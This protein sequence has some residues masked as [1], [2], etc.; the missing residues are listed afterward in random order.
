MALM[1]LQ[2]FKPTNLNTASGFSQVIHLGL[3]MLLPLAMLALVR[4]QFV[5][6]A[7]VLM[8]LSKWRMLAVQPRFWPTN[9]RAN[10]VDILVG[11]SIL[12]F[13]AKVE[14]AWLAL[15]WALVYG[16]WLI[17]VKPLTT[18]FGI[19]LQA[20][21]GQLAGLSAL[22]LYAAD[23]SLY[24]LVLATGL[25]CYLVARHFF[26]AF[27]ESYSRLLSAAWAYFAAALMWVLGHW[28]LFYGVM[29]QPTLI[30]VVLS[31]G[32]AVLYY[33]DH[34]ERLGTVLRRQTLIIMAAIVLVVL[35]LSKWVN[36][37]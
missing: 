29:A 6:L 16:L 33:F 19:S 11:L 25:I 20:G 32:L 17:Y 3:Q 36:P 37:V 26:D 15:I 34:H 35:I 31:Y 14:T 23:A 4:A 13:M 8:L 18:T 9:I 1:R 12:V 21:F 2:I 24:W 10:S 27:D 7:L 30:L 28:L 22:F 5:W